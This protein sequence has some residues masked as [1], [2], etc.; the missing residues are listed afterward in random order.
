[1]HGKQ[2]IEKVRLTELP[3]LPYSLPDYMG[4]YRVFEGN[5]CM[6]AYWRCSPPSPLKDQPHKHEGYGVV[7]ETIILLKGKMRIFSGEESTV[8]EA[9]EAVSYLGSEEHQSEILEPVEAFMIVAPPIKVRTQ[10]AQVEYV[11]KGKNGG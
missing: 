5:N 8:V 3:K 7:E 4:V 10:G 9:G 11:A 2:R 1:M 6:I